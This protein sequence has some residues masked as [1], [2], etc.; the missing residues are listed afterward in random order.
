[1]P[2]IDL[3]TL[4]ELVGHLNDSNQDGNASDRFRKYLRGNIVSASDARDYVRDA[5]T[6]SGDQYNKALQDLINH[7]GHLLGFEVIYGR[8]RGVHGE[9]GF[10]GLWKSPSGWSIVV[11]AKTTDVYTVRT[12]TLLGYINSLVSVGDIPNTSNTLGLYIY[13]RFDAKSNQLENAII[14]EG[15][16]EKL[17]LVS[18]E[19]LLNLL[20]LKQDY[21]L[22]HGTVLDLL[23]PAPVRVDSLVNL[24]RDVVAQEQ[25]DEIFAGKE[26]STTIDLFSPIESPHTPPIK[27]KFEQTKKLVQVNYNFT[28]KTAAS[29]EVFGRKVEVN[30]WK[31][32]SLIV[33]EALAARDLGMFLAA[34]QSIHGRKR[35]YFS[36]QKDELR[37]PGAVLGTELFFE[38][39]LSANSLVKL[40]FTLFDK[41]E[42]SR[43]DLV[44]ESAD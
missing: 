36:Y 27:Y 1:M 32:A 26:E 3:N 22:E 30:T 2:Q 20:E 6:N 37:Q 5:L 24:I 15:R 40:C 34:A 33:F 35:P 31:D 8:Y 12:D 39:N 10:D 29:V 17:R 41:L 4:L 13:G 19:A 14:V 25:E 18:V 28:G 43:D 38:T 44:F 23:K 9:I 42:H 7:I 11:E 16:R 21:E